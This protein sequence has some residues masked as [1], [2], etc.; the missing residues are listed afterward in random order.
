MLFLPFQSLLY[1]FLFTLFLNLQFSA[2]LFLDGHIMRGGMSTFLS[3]SAPAALLDD[4]QGKGCERTGTNSAINAASTHL[5][6]LPIVLFS[7]APQR[8]DESCLA[9][10]MAAL[11]TFR[12]YP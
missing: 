4:A 3:S 7:L 12:A 5:S 6:T 11:L 1:A 10:S 8:Q 2:L 9:A